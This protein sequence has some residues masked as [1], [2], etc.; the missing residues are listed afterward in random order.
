MQKLAEDLKMKHTDAHK[1]REVYETKYQ[2]A[3]RSQFLQ[4]ELSLRKHLDETA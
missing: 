4:F 1:A 2:S 3:F